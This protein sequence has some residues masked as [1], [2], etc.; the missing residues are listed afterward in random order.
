[1]RRKCSSQE[2]ELD[3]LKQLLY[4]LRTSS[5]EEVGKLVMEI[6]SYEDPIAALNSYHNST[7]DLCVATE[8]TYETNG[9][10]ELQSDL[11][12]GFK[13][14][15]YLTPGVSIQA[16]T[17]PTAV[18]S[19]S[20]VSHLVSEYLI[21]ERPVQLPPINFKT[22]AAEINKGDT[23]SENY[24]SDLLVNAIC[25]HQCFLSYEYSEG[26]VTRRNLGRKFLDECYRLLR[27]K[28][29]GGRI[30]LPTAQ[31]MTLIYQA[32]LIDHVFDLPSEM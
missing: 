7:E 24:Y 17:L 11:Q 14:E 23:A 30:T 31:A 3:S 27:L 10:P 2:G 1:M 18:A 9:I 13:P 16:E 32:E 28:I 25:A 21:L 5:P 19:S 20:H 29:K 12:L 26:S 4:Q 6:R 8:A 15:S 22:F